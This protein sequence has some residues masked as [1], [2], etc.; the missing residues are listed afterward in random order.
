MRQA[1]R[2]ELNIARDPK[3][4]RRGYRPRYPPAACAKRQRRARA[5][6]AAP[7]NVSI[8]TTNRSS[9]T[10]NTSIINGSIVTKRV[11]IVAISSTITINER[12]ASIYGCRSWTKALYRTELR[13][14]QEREKSSGAG[15]RESERARERESERA[16]EQERERDSDSDRDRDRDRDRDEE[17]E[18]RRENRPAA[19]TAAE[20]SERRSTRAPERRVSGSRH[21]SPDSRT[22]TTS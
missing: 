10:M 13:A 16:R 20:E 7:K 8:A 1:G 11:G 18:K 6:K 14:R 12:T 21:P 9:V 19:A 2:H 15:G 3:L 5:V 17:G 4:G 22:D